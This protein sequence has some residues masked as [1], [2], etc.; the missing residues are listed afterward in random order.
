MP[1]KTGKADLRMI[2][3]VKR[4]KIYGWTLPVG[5]VIK[6]CSNDRVIADLDK[7]GQ[8]VCLLEGGKGGLGN[9]NFATPTNQAPDYAQPGLPGQARKIKLELKLIADVALVGFPNV[10]KS[11]LISKLSAAKPVIANYPF[12]TL[13]PNLGMV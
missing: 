9:M 2:A 12:T 10:G 3:T 11:T 1:L 8:Q 7:D 6:D 13:V 5:T 4:G